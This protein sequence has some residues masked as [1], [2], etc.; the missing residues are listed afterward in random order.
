MTPSATTPVVHCRNCGAPAIPL[1]APGAAFCRY[2]GAYQQPTAVAP[3]REGVIVCET[4][5]K[6]ACPLCAETLHEAVVAERPAAICT[7]CGGLL[8]AMEH[9]ALI[10]RTRRAEYTGLE[11][12]PQA[13]NRA[14][15]E[16]DVRCPQCAAVMETH[17]YGGAGNVVIDTCASCGLVWLDPGE[18]TALERAPG[19]R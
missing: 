14:E 3:N 16:R 18:L 9:F 4:H 10:I 2:C 19:R 5:A 12:D 11:N 15:L 6:L 8:C 17:P 1:R 7:G 13:L